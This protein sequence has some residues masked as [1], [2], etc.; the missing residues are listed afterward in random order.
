MSLSISCVDTLNYEGSYHAI[1]RTLETLGNK[2]DVVYW[3]SDK[4][5]PKMNVPV[6]WT[7]IEPMSGQNDYSYVTLNICPTVCKSDY[8]LI[9]QWD[10]YA[11]NPDAWTDE[12]LEYDYIGATWDDGE[13]GNGGFS[14][15]SKKLYKAMREL[16]VKHLFTDFPIELVDRQYY[17]TTTENGQKFVPED[18]VICRLYKEELEKLGIRYAPN[19][20]ADRFSI[21]NHSHIPPWR[22]SPNP[23]LGTSLGFHGK[24]GIRNYY[25]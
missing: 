17:H 3:Y 15:R 16:E 8:D 20:L 18:V 13:V 7:K 11:C 21:E 10:G 14:L 25:K 1:R 23:W 22:A 24:F 6:K 19:S 2:V 9:V 12:F 4:P 5:L